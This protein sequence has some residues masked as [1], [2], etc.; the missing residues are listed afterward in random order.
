METFVLSVGGRALPLM[1]A[2]VGV[3]LLAMETMVYVAYG[4]WRWKDACAKRANKLELV[5]GEED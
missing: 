3:L 2:A 5:S 4:F 1:A